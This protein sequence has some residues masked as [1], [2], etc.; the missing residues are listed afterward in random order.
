MNTQPVSGVA[1][2]H[3]APREPFMKKETI[4]G[5]KFALKVGGLVLAIPA[6][7]VGAFLSLSTIIKSSDQSEVE[8]QRK[9]AQEQQAQDLRKTTDEARI[10]FK[11][12]LPVR[13]EAECRFDVFEHY[14]VELP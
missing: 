10:Y 1:N 11:Y 12:C 7:A 13:R 8:N 3:A 2:N 9:Y 14:K 6:L 4:Q 5:I